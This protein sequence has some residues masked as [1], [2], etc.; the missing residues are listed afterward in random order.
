[1]LFRCPF[2]Q[3]SGAI[4]AV[5]DGYKKNHP[6]TRL[7]LHSAESLIS[8]ALALPLGPQV[9]LLLFR[10]GHGRVGPRVVQ[11]RAG[12]RFSAIFVAAL[13]WPGE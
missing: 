1:M 11:K 10:E 9:A 6:S 5:S 4:F 7:S 13:G 12:P 3:K 2:V 8:L